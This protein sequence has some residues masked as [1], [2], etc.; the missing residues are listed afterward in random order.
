M[1]MRKGVKTGKFRVLTEEQILEIHH[2][3]LQIL[4]IKGL[5]VDSRDVL[6]LLKEN[7]CTV[8][9]ER[10]I[11]RIPGYLVE[12]TVKKAPSC[13]R[14]SGRKREDDILMESGRSYFGEGCGSMNVLE[15]DGKMRKPVKEDLEKAAKLGDALPNI[16]H[17]WGLYTRDFYNY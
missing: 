9:F 2:G 11:A 8:D 17:V 13:F 16:D 6:N 1:G 10:R 5:R 12:E 14:L 4:E 3:V 7:G 15:Y